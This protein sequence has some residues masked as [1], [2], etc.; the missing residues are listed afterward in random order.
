M[1]QRPPVYWMQLT[2]SM[3]PTGSTQLGNKY[4]K[5]SASTKLAQKANIIIAHE[6]PSHSSAPSFSSNICAVALKRGWVIDVV[7]VVGVSTRCSS[8]PRARREDHQVGV[9]STRTM[10]RSIRPKQQAGLD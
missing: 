2:R 8:E 10:D 5:L 7:R 3:Q 9:E 1:A 4:I 6:Y